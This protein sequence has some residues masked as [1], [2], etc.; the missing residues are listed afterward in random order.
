MRSNVYNRRFVYVVPRKACSGQH[1]VK[2]E[3]LCQTT[4]PWG[5]L[6]RDPFIFLKDYFSI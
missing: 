3:L 2:N 4:P 5:V 1:L 6:P